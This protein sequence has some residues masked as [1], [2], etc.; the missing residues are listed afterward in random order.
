MRCGLWNARIVLMLVTALTLS[1]CASV[2]KNRWVELTPQPVGAGPVLHITGT[3]HHLDLEGGLFVIRDRAGT[4]FNPV[5]LPAGF[6]VEGI[7]VE[8]E[9]QRRDDA[10][11]IGMVGPMIELLRI[12][13]HAGADAG[14]SVL[15]GTKW[16]LEDP[17]G[18]DVTD[19]VQATLEF[20]EGGK[21]SGNGS[22][23]QFHGTVTFDGDTI[24]F[25][26]LATTR[27]FCGEAVMSQENQYLA[28]L[29]G[30]QRFEVRKP[31]LYI[32]GAGKSQPLRLVGTQE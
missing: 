9:A 20:A 5:N 18:A 21:V 19:R 12:R 15:V 32:Y 14:A 29:R 26:P 6:R 3:V 24:K 31:F 16:R 10:A 1:S 8:T 23:N 28:A 22:C 13:R 25:G 30:A 7:A 11:S 27:K 2:G 4:Q 17:A